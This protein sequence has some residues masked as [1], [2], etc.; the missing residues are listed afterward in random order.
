MSNFIFKVN[1]FLVKVAYAQTSEGGKDFFK[2]PLGSTS[3]FAG[4]INNILGVLIQIGVPVLVIF[5][6]YTGYLFVSAQGNEK[7]IEE[8]KMAL[9]WAVI[10]GAVLL[11]AKVIA[12]AVQNTVKAVQP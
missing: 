7:K 2:N 11:G 12:T 3:D 10:G 4:L 8:A 9:F 5:I 1:L 6:V